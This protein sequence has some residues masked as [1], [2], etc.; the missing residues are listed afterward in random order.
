MNEYFFNWIF[1]LWFKHFHFFLPY[2]FAFPDVLLPILLLLLF[3][4]L[5]LSWFSD[6][7]V[8]IFKNQWEA[9]MCS[10]LFYIFNQPTEIL[11]WHEDI[12]GMEPN[13]SDIVLSDRIQTIVNTE[14]SIDEMM[15]C[16]RE[17][18]QDLG[19]EKQI[20]KVCFHLRFSL[21]LVIFL[22]CRTRWKKMQTHSKS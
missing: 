2:P 15:K 18:I 22:N 3:S 4:S 5:L 19:K 13:L 17:I 16:A 9:Y 21:K 20:G 6:K 14:K 10:L 7:S 8:K 1:Q 12:S 11:I